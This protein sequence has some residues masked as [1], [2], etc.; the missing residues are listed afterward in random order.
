MKLLILTQKVD[1]DDDVLGFFHGWLREFARS[2]HT[3]TVICLEKGGFDLPENVRVLSL[4]KERGRGRLGYAVRFLRFIWRERKA[5]D[6]VF[7][8][9]NKEYVLLGAWFWKMSGKKVVLWYNHPHADFQARLAGRW[10]DTV[11]YTSPQS[12]FGRN[13]IGVRMP[14]GIDTALFADKKENCPPDSLLYLG[15]ISPIKN[16][17]ALI[18]AVVLA[19]N[20]NVACTLSIVGNALPRD[21]DYYEKIVNDARPLVKEKRVR[22]LE[23]VSYHKAPAVYNGHAVFVNLTKSGS[24]DKTIFEAMACERLVIASNE[25]FSELLPEEYRRLLVFREN[26]AQDLASCIERTLAL[27]PHVREGLGRRFREIILA[28]HSLELLSRKL[29][30]ILR[31]SNPGAKNI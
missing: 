12:Y 19:K 11:L 15:R 18:R 3:V 7:V 27:P 17:D 31:E 1:Y 20:R 10:A 14:V 24:F 28:R 4:G 29:L 5:Y 30:G 2:F 21:R 25:G 23:G 13:N 8:H 6:S 26:D 16:V 9:M 22:F